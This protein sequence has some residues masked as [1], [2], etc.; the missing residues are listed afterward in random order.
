MQL[1]FSKKLG[2]AKFLLS[3]VRKPNPEDW[4]NKKHRINMQPF[5]GKIENHITGMAKCS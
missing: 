4:I 5:D 3:W 2:N 1:N